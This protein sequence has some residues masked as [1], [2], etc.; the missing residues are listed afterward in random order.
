MKPDLL[1]Y[2][3]GLAAPRAAGSEGCTELPQVCAAQMPR[4]RCVSHRCV[5]QAQSSD[6]C[7]S[8]TLAP[9]TSKPG[10]LCRS[11]T[12]Q[13]CQGFIFDPTVHAGVFVSLFV[14]KWVP[15]TVTPW[16]DAEHVS[17]GPQ[18]FS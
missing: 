11:G 13:L 3:D 9:G 15:P 14:W 10:A 16:W 4:A 2:P 12:A 5:S 17:P 7:P 18:A 6:K 1:H 8:A